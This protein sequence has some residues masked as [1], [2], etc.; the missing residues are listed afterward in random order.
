M[1]SISSDGFTAE[2][3]SSST[4]TRGFATSA[5]ASEMRWR[6]PPD[7]VRPR[8]PT[9]A[10]EATVHL[11]DHLVGAGGAQ[12]GDQLVVGDLAPRAEQQVVAQRRGEQE[13]LLGHDAD[14]AP[15]LGRVELVEREA[16]EPRL[17]GSGYSS[18]AAMPARVDLPDPGAPWTTTNSPGATERWSPWRKRR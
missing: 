1:I 15:Q 5:R 4:S 13:R 6:W 9:D 17:P 11:L 14:G 8:S 18:P 7:T 3:A 2:S 10:V 12:R 16:V